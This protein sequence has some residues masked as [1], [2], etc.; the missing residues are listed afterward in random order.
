M[1]QQGDALISESEERAHVKEVNGPVVAAARPRS[2][3][4]GSLIHDVKN[5]LGGPSKEWSRSRTYK[6]LSSSLSRSP[7]AGTS[8]TWVILS[9]EDY[10]RLRA[11]NADEF[12][13]FCD[14]VEQAAA[15]GLTEDAGRDSCR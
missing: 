9:A 7:S 1:G 15:R 12:Q 10:D 13:R 3:V 2:T 8:A 5:R 6:E 11:L 4:P 14:R